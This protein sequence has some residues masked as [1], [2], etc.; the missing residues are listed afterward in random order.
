MN[1]LFHS[2][3]KKKKPFLNIILNA[4]IAMCCGKRLDPDQPAAGSGVETLLF[5]FLQEQDKTP[6]LISFP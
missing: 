4:D 1:E 3:R 2:I 5:P 6:T